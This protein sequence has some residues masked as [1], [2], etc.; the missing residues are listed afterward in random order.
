[1]LKEEHRSGA[2]IN[3]TFSSWPQTNQTINQFLFISILQTTSQ[4]KHP[5]G[6]SG[7]KSLHWLTSVYKATPYLSCYPSLNHF[8]VYFFDMVWLELCR[9]FKMKQHYAS[10]QNTVTLL[11]SVFSPLCLSHH[12][13]L[14][15]QGVGC[16]GF[17]LF[18]LWFE[19]IMVCMEFFILN[20][21]YICIC[22][23]YLYWLF[24]KS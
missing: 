13:F 5:S 12:F 24:L 20:P 7:S 2:C 16:L 22:H 9:S 1:M 14:R 8:Q 11:C 17:F 21:K 23:I 4:I 6:I 10:I 15:L 3:Y 19:W 18:L